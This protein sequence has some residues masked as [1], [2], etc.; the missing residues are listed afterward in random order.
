PLFHEYP[1]D[2]QTYGID[3]QFMWGSVVLFSPFLFENQTEVNA[4]LPDDVW[5]EPTEDFAKLY[6]NRGHVKLPDSRLFPPFHLRGGYILPIGCDKA[7]N[8]QMLREKP[9]NLEVYPKNKSA[10]GDMYWDD[11]DSLN[12]IETN[13]YNFYEFELLSNC[14]LHIV[15]KTKGY[16]SEKPQIIEKV[17]IANTFNAKINALVDGKPVESVVLKDDSTRISVNIDL[18]SGKVGQKWVIDWKT[19]DNTCNLK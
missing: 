2:P 6:P 8:T 5:Y 12:T 1:T 9:I 18:N 17:L 4:Y 11:G 7:I 19:A 13:H 3:E 15:V 16:N 10:K 14:S